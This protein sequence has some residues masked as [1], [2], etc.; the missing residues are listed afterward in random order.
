[1][2]LKKILLFACI[3]ILFTACDKR[4]AM[5]KEIQKIQTELLSNITNLDKDKAQ[6]LITK[7]QAYA[8]AFPK[9]TSSARV[10]FKAADVARGIGDYPN[11]MKMWNEVQVNFEQTKY[12]SESLFLQGFTFENDL[13]DIE[14]A[15]QSYLKFINL[16]PNHELADDAAMALKNIDTPLEDLIKTF[17]AKNKAEIEAEAK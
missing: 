6:L 10:L 9:D 7:S 12:A 5:Q 14:K 8:L 3:G 17:E 2:T 1:M 13:Q 16:Y 11:A 4:A 15:K